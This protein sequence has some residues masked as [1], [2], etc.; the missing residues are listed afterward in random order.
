MRSK[1]DARI[2]RQGGKRKPKPIPGGKAL[3]RLFY[4]LGE[5]DPALNN[6]V[7]ASIAVP[8]AARPRFGLT[9]KALGA[10]PATAATFAKAA[11]GRRAPPAAKS[12]AAAIVK[13]A[14]GLARGPRTSA[15]TGRLKA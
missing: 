4:Y 15:R 2:E 14:T 10:K 6:D 5:R 12:F 8:K 7:V 1:F 11:R 3:Q 9:K 13:A